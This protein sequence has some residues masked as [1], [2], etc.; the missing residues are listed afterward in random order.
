M[1]QRRMELTFLTEPL[2]YNS[3]NTSS[4]NP[5]W[6]N[7]NKPLRNAQTRH[8]GPTTRP[9][10]P[11][12]ITVRPYNI[13]ARIEKPVGS[14]RQSQFIFTQQLP[15]YSYQNGFRKENQK[16]STIIPTIDT[17]QQVYTSRIQDQV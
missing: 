17:S 4:V 8:P 9:R 11:T 1:P 2:F 12:R 14:F 6:N 13:P 3:V 5:N 7:Q 15:S 16:L 10:F